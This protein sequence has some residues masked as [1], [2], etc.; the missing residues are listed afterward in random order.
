[1]FMG[2]SIIEWFSVVIFIVGIV[3]GSIKHSWKHF[4]LFLSISV[5]MMSGKTGKVV[6]VGDRIFAD[7][8]LVAIGVICLLKILKE[9]KQTKEEIENLKS[10]SYYKQ[11][12]KIPVSAISNTNTFDKLSKDESI[13][14]ASDAGSAGEYRLYDILNQFES[15]TFKIVLNTFVPKKDNET[16]EIDM[17]CITSFGFLVLESKNYSGWIFGSESSDTWTQNMYGTKNTFYNPIRQNKN[18]IKAL[19]EYTHVDDKHMTSIIVFSDKCELKEV[20]ASKRETIIIQAKDLHDLVSFLIQNRD[21]VF[22]SAQI[23]DFYNQL[24]PLTSPD[25][26]TIQKHIQDTK[27]SKFANLK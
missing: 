3:I 17:I 19:S 5:L 24:L 11:T 13:T 20:P 26:K 1:M 4:L 23:N 6:P 9:N 21:S 27:F 22:S 16:A 8:V 14:L 18:H 12:G 25:D 15:E 10:T 2:Y 7:L